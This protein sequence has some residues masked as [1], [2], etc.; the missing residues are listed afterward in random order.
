MHLDS[1][2]GGVPAQRWLPTVRPFFPSQPNRPPLATRPTPV[3]ITQIIKPFMD[4]TTRDKVHMLHG[5][6][7]TVTAALLETI[8]AEEL[9]TPY[10]GK[11]PV[12]EAIQRLHAK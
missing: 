3:W 12:P 11:L 5:D 1:S 9:L 4:A 2:C 6:A 10:G 7:A 8:A